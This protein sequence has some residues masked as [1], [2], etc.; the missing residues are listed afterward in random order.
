M[1][2]NY[3]D[4]PP[5]WRELSRYVRFVRAGGRCEQC[6]VAH[7]AVGARDTYG[8]WHDEDSIHNMN[9][10]AGDALFGE[11]PRMVKIVLTTAHLNHDTGDNRL[12]NLKALC[13]KCH[14]TYDAPHHAVNAAKTRRRKKR[15]AY[16]DA[17]NVP[18]FEEKQS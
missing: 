6:G 13:Q 10:G 8:V 11:F 1:P 5:N 16:L 2:M 14:L 3:A 4:Y 7:G 15:Q 18:L 9:A 12:S 17:G